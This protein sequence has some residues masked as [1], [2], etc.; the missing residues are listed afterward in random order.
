MREALAQQAVSLA[1][2]PTQKQQAQ[3]TLTEVTAQSGLATQN[4]AKTLATITG[5][6]N[7]AETDAAGAYQHAQDVASARI[8]A[9]TSKLTITQADAS[10]A[11]ARLAAALQHLTDNATREEQKLTD[12]ITLTRAGGSRRIKSDARALSYVGGDDGGLAVGPETPYRTSS[13]KSG[14]VNIENVNVNSAPQMN[15]GELVHEMYLELRS[16]STA[17]PL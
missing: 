6:V 2:T 17:P 15:T 14:G 1:R 10:R 5:N 16:L 11:E 7:R 13:K 8:T 4:A 3:N 9:A 12:L